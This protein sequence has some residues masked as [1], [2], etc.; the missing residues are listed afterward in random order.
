MENKVKTTREALDMIPD[1]AV[2]ASSGFVLWGTPDWLF[3][4]LEDRFL[5]PG[6]PNRL[7]CVFLC[8]AC[9]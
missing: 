5:E 2:V 6:H 7:E 4:A 3:K 9:L 8:S 1:G